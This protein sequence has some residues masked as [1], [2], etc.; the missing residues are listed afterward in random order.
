MFE[1]IHNHDFQRKKKTDNQIQYDL[2]TGLES[3]SYSIILN[4]NNKQKIFE[5]IFSSLAKSPIF[6]D[7]IFF[8]EEIFKIDLLMFIINKLY[9]C[10]Y[11]CIHKNLEIFLLSIIKT[12]PKND[13]KLLFEMC[14]LYHNKSQKKLIHKLIEEAI[15]NCNI[16]QLDNNENNILFFTDQVLAKTFLINGLDINHKN[17][18]GNNFIQ[19]KL[20]NTKQIDRLKII[21]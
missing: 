12:I 16:H 7:N 3:S 9:N 6:I 14:K 20:I 15:I 1:A 13:G 11:N 21:F 19:W 8:E 17:I 4:Q 2:L 18:D 10:S 5:E